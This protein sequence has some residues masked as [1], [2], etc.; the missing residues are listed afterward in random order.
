[1]IFYTVALPESFARRYGTPLQGGV[2][3]AAQQME[4]MVMDGDVVVNDASSAS[5]KQVAYR[6]G[7]DGQWCV[8]AATMVRQE[9]VADFQRQ[10][11]PVQKVYEQLNSGAFSTAADAQRALE[12]ALPQ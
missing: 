4:S 1:M 8:D 11:E 3:K 9:D 2:G 6:R 7:T 12:R 10:I 5:G